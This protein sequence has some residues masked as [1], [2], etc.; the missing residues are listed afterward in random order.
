MRSKGW[1]KAGAAWR[2]AGRACGFALALPALICFAGADLGLAAFAPAGFDFAFLDAA[3]LALA[4]G[5]TAV[6]PAAVRRLPAAAFLLADFAF[7]ALAGMA[8]LS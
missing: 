8:F 4:A 2:T 3:L 5:F 6:L 7:N 1:G